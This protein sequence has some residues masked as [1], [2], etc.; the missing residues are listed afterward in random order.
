[1]Y[2]N[3]IFSPRGCRMEQS[4]S[5][6]RSIA[7]GLLATKRMKSISSTSKKYHRKLR[8]ASLDEAMK[9]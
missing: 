2:F 3:Y 6:G 4:T 9:V 7:H 5:T 1:M 8:Y